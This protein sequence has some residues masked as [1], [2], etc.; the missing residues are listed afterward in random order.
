M[1]EEY[2]TNGDGLVLADGTWN[3]KIPTIDTI[4]KQFNV[5]ILNSGHHQHRV[6]SSK[7]IFCLLNYVFILVFFIVFPHKCISLILERGNQFNSIWIIVL[8]KW[9]VVVR[10]LQLVCCF[11]V[12]D[13]LLSKGRAWL[14]TKLDI[15]GWNNLGLTLLGSFLLGIKAGSKT[16]R[17]KKKVK[18]SL[19]PV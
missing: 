8:G 3:Y 16:S 18:A 15:W 9:I 14:I 1:L 5:Q 2:E 10:M 13:W 11:S 12:C 19:I 7:G 6:L 17:P 4:P